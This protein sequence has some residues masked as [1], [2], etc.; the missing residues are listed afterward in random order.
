MAKELGCSRASVQ[1]GLDMLYEAQWVE[2]RANGRGQ[3]APES[4]EYPFAAYSYRV[5]LDR[6]NL[7]IVVAEMTRLKPNLRLLPMP[8]GVPPQR[9]GVPPCRQ[10]VPL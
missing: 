5:L 6:E 2:K 10:G 7:P 9:Q 3:R 4:S 1:D 8:W